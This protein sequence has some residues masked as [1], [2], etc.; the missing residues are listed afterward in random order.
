MKILKETT[1]WY[2]Y[3][4]N[5]NM[6]QILSTDRLVSTENEV[7]KTAIYHL[8][9]TIPLSAFPFTIKENTKSYKLYNEIGELYCRI[10]KKN[11][12]K[13]SFV[14]NISYIDITYKMTE[15]WFSHNLKAHVYVALMEQFKQEATE[16]REDACE[17][18]N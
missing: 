10:R 11:R 3:K 17:T 15:D 6:G 8:D 2:L 13:Y 1:V 18:N 9:N 12:D 16:K 7:E 14:R 5:K 4:N